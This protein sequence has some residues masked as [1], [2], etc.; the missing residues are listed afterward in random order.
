MHGQNEAWLGLLPFH[1]DD[2]AAARFQLT[3]LH[4][5]L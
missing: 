3:A 1:D 5:W 4:P 2:D